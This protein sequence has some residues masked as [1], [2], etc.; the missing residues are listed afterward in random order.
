M[1]KR[2]ATCHREICPL[3]QA[4]RERYEI[5]RP[6]QQP[7]EY[8]QFNEFILLNSLS[9]LDPN[10]QQSRGRPARLTSQSRQDHVNTNT[11]IV[12]HQ[13]FRIYKIRKGKGGVE[14]VEK[15]YTTHGLVLSV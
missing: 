13:F 12:V 2:V 14:F 6:F 1:H 3:F 11:I 7:Q 8:D 10:I 5:L 9:A 15:H 4:V